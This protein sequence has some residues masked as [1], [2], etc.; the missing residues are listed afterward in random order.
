[1]T[2]KPPSPVNPQ[3]MFLWNIAWDLKALGSKCSCEAVPDTVS[4]GAL[5]RYKGTTVTGTPLD[6]RVHLRHADDDSVHLDV[7]SESPGVSWS[8]ARTLKNDDLTPKVIRDMFVAQFGTSE[9]ET[10]C[11]HVRDGKR[12]RIT[13]EDKGPDK[14]GKRLFFLEW[15]TNSEERPRRAQIFRAVPT[16]YVTEDEVTP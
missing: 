6:F 10:N 9:L 3:I 12:M 7:R 14:E 2:A 4:Q 8:Y 15:R 5:L 11:T 13:Y 1:M 16:D